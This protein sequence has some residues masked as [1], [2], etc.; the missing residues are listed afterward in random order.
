MK[1]EYEETNRFFAATAKGLEDILKK[2]LTELGAKKCSVGKR[3]VYFT[4][5]KEVLYRI[6]Y[7][8]T[9]GFRV[10][11]PII[12][13]ECKDDSDLYN[14][15]YNIDWSRFITPNH[16][17]AIFA[18]IYNHPNII[19][20]NYASLKLKDAIADYFRDK[21]GRRPNVA[22][23]N[24]DIWF[25]INLQG[26]KAIISVDTSGGSLHRRGYR[27]ETTEAPLQE[28]LAAAII[29]LSGWDGET[30]F[31]DPMCGSG[32]FIAEA[33]MKYCRIPAAFMKKRFGFFLLPDF[34]R[35]IWLKVKEEALGK[36]RPYKDGLI[37]GTDIDRKTVT[38]TK[39]NLS[40]IPGADKIRIDRW[41]FRELKGIEN[42]TIITNP[43]YGVRLEEKE[44][45]KQLYRDL[46]DF[47][48]QKCK[49]TTAWI[50][51]GDKRLSGELRLKASARYN[52]FNGGIE[53][54]LVKIEI[55]T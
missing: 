40:L 49:G 11:A 47:L 17:F 7:T 13:F 23:K 34:D 35:D 54:S 27:Q 4:A 33:Y 46:G 10:F 42:A 14:V 28:T 16:T 2:E 20:S 15:A 1:F 12:T 21:F 26:T 6:N 31:F 39:G 32:T 50:L 53:T 5:S 18:N 9:T 8:V 41:D 55:F 45:V 36:I 52:M 25:N 19:H 51:C 48:K 38:K 44:K 24:P 29:R 37:E 22:P 3:G 30:K 43:P